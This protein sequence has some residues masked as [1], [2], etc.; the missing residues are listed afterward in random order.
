MKP[1]NLEEALSDKPV[2]TRDG[3]PI[4]IA[5]YNEEAESFS[6]VAGWFDG[7]V[8]CWSKDGRYY[9]DKESE[10]DLFMAVEKREEWV[11]YWEKNGKR[12]YSMGMSK[13]D[14]ERFT[15]AAKGTILKT[16]KIYEEDI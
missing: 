6:K 3:R 8:E 1:F 12:S 16:I 5:G 14:A 10:Y 4:K 9:D 13:Q 2:V 7:I 15:Y 11:C